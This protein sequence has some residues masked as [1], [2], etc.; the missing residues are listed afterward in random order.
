MFLLKFLVYFK[1]VGMQRFFSINYM[2]IKR[3]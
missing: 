1:S 2:K 3:F